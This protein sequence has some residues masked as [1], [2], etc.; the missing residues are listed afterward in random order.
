MCKKERERDREFCFEKTYLFALHHHKYLP[1]RMMGLMLYNS[2]D[3]FGIGVDILLD[4]FSH[5]L[6]SP[7][8]IYEFT[9]YSKSGTNH[10]LLSG[11]KKF[12]KSSRL[13][14]I[15]ADFVNKC[16]VVRSTNVMHFDRFQR[17]CDGSMRSD[18]INLHFVMRVSPN[19]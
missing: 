2:S 18:Q 10:L 5:H 15:S 14:R 3:Y 1:N 9:Y 6:L 13:P 17:D 8:I 7:G 4:P 19:P 16:A 12:T 11:K